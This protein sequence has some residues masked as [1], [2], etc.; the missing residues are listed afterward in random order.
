MRMKAMSCSTTMSDLVR[1][2]ARTISAVRPTSSWFMPAAGS[3]SRMRSGS[4]LSTVPISTHCRCP[5]ASVPTMR[6]VE[7]V[8]AISPSTSSTT[9]S[10]ALRA[11]LAPRREPQVLADREAVEDR[12]RLRLDPDAGAGDGVGEAPAMSRPRYWTVPALGSNWPVSILKNVLL[13]APFGPMRQRSS[14]L[15]QGE[16]DRVHRHHS[17]EAHREAAGLEQGG[18]HDRALRGRGAVTGAGSAPSARTR[19]PVPRR[20]R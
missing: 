18:G 12:G 13:P 19:A 3:S 14:P 9:A 8:S 2:M 1:L 15:L 11:V 5:W 7:P 10:G 4:P 6:S 17:A 16:V 20:H